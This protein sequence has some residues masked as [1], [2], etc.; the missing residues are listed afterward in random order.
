MSTVHPFRDSSEL[1]VRGHIGDTQRLHCGCDEGAWVSAE[2]ERL[3]WDRKLLKGSLQGRQQ[4]GL[5]CLP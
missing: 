1:S 2:P 3:D 4:L 5:L